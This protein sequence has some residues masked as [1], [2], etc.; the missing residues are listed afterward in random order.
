MLVRCG[1]ALR[2]NEGVRLDLRP[3]RETKG[4]PVLAVGG[5][6]ERRGVFFWHASSL[7]QNAV[8]NDV[9]STEDDHALR[10]AMGKL[11]VVGDE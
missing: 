3:G 10:A 9:P 6:S 8:A 7:R 1:T 11:V 4:S 5:S 2:R